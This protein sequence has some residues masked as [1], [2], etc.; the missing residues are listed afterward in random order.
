MI[1]R[2]LFTVMVSSVVA[3]ST[4]CGCL[5]NMLCS[6]PGYGHGYGQAAFSPC[7]TGDCGACSACTTCDSLGSCGG[8]CDS[9]QCFPWLRSLFKCDGCGSHYWSEWHSDPPAACEQCDDHGNWT[10]GTPVEEATYHDLRSASNDRSVV[11]RP[12]PITVAHQQ[13][14]LAR[15]PAS[16]KPRRSRPLHR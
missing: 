15:N 6:Q 14:Q 11:R 16:R 10:G 5:G 2:L 1:K 4:G 12:G 3:A 9:G 7:E 13:P 8:N